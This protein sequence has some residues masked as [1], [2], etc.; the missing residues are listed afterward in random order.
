MKNLSWY[1]FG[2]ALL[3]AIVLLVIGIWKPFTPKEFVAPKPLSGEVDPAALADAGPPPPGY[4]KYE[5]TLYGFSFYHAP[6]AK[7]REESEGQ[8]SMTIVLENFDKVRGMQIFIVPYSEPTISP[9]RFHADV[10]SGIR[11]NEEMTTVGVKKIPAVTFTSVDEQLGETRELWFIHNGFLF[12]V[13]TF[14]GVRDWFT[15]IIQSWR[16]VD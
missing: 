16:F 7:I 13:T 14:K 6:E 10:P 8:G 2:A 1:A 12:E 15:P 3:L 9:E 4:V 11:E 5:N